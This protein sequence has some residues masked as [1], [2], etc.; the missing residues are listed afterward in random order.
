MLALQ[1]SI[2]EGGTKHE[3]RSAGTGNWN[4]AFMEFSS[5]EIFHLMKKI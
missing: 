3:E 5:F 4:F 2:E 1:T